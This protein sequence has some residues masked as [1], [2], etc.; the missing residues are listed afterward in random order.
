MSEINL[1][2]TQMR[3]L[4]R[5]SSE[6]LLGK[7]RNESRRYYEPVERTRPEKRYV[8]TVLDRS[9]RTRLRNGLKILRAQSLSDQSFLFRREAAALAGVKGVGTVLKAERAL[10]EG[11]LIKRYTL[12]LHRTDKCLWEILPPGYNSLQMTQPN[13]ESKGEYLHK[14]CAHRIAATYKKS[15]Y[16]T[17]IEHKRSDGKLV[18]LK[19]KSLDHDLFIEICASKPLEKEISN[20]ELDLR[21]PPF[22][23][24]LLIAITDRA[25]RKPLERLI[26]KRLSNYRLPSQVRVVLAGDLIDHPRKSK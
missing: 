5:K 10:I 2:S 16:V 22:P 11:G 7:P 3:E 26:E 25:M 6:A 24:E 23:D 8:R 15:G 20:I 13:W 12:P 9:Q 1:T 14:F 4:S 21:T 17:D 19:V 18:D